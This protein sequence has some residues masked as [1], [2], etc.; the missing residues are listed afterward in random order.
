MAA[1]E[2]WCQHSADMLHL[3][4]LTSFATQRLFYPILRLLSYN[5][6]PIGATS[7]LSIVPVPK[8]QAYAFAFPRRLGL[9]SPFHTWSEHSM[10]PITPGAW[11]RLLTGSCQTKGS[12][13]VWP[14]TFTEGSSDPGVGVPS[15]VCCDR[16]FVGASVSD[17][18]FYTV[19]YWLNAQLN[20]PPPLR[21][22]GFLPEADLTELKEAILCSKIRRPHCITLQLKH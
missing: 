8:C 4:C 5:T 19:G 20:R 22:L 12:L 2:Q 13:R 16:K 10:R 21:K 3:H 7:L 14:F 17:F 15:R 1:A 9:S 11:W 6:C 18:F